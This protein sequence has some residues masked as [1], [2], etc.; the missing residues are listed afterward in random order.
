MSVRRGPK[1]K[2]VTDSAFMNVG[3][4]IHVEKLKEFMASKGVR[5]AVG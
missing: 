5:F 1:M 3:R 2:H 4:C